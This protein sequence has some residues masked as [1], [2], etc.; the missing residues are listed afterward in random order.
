[1]CQ[2]IKFCHQF[3]RMFSNFWQTSFIAK[4]Y[5][6]IHFNTHH[7][8][9]YFIHEENHNCYFSFAHKKVKTKIGAKFLRLIDQHFP[10]SNP[11]SK[12]FNRNTLKI[13]YRCTPNLAKFISSH[14]AKILRQTENPVVDRACNCRQR[15]SCPLDGNCLQENLVY[16]ATVSHDGGNEETYIGLTSNSFKSRHANHKKSFTYQKYETETELSKHVWNVK[17][18]VARKMKKANFNIKWKKLVTAKPFNPVTNICNLCTVEKYL[19]IFKPDLGT[20]NK[21]DE[22]RNHCRH[23]RGQLLDKT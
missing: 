14:N 15:A 12:I 13:S 19:I 5:T 3:S 18:R 4:L 20:L 9:Q 6:K 10:K 2:I 23:K 1:M 17:K 22:I 11:L 21:R 8:P 16:Q 7:Q